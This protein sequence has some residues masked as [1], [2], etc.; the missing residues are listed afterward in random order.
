MIH[1]RMRGTAVKH[2]FSSLQTQSIW[3]RWFHGTGA[4]FTT[5]SRTRRPVSWAGTRMRRPAEG[6]RGGR[7]A[8][9][10]KVSLAAPL[11][12]RDAGTNHGQRRRL[13]RHSR[14]RS[15]SVRRTTEVPH[16]MQSETILIGGRRLGAPVRFPVVDPATLN[17]LVECSDATD[18]QASQAVDAAAAELRLWSSTPADRR[19]VLLNGLALLLEAEIESLSKLIVLE[20]GKPRP[21]AAR[22]VMSAAAALRWAGEEG[23]RVYGQ[24]IPSSSRDL[25]IWTYPQPLGVV[26]AMTGWQE[27][28]AGLARRAGAALAAGCTL[29]V[30]PAA[31]TPLS[32]VEFGV[33]ARDAGIPAG[34]VNVVTSSRTREVTH[35]WMNDPRIRKVCY[36][37]PA[38]LGR[39]LMRAASDQ[40]Q[41]LSLE[42][43]TN[44][45]AL[46]FDD[47]HPAEAA[48][49]VLSSRFRQSGQA[50]GSIQRVYLQEQVADAVEALLVRGARELQTGNGMNAGVDCGPLID[51]AAFT[52]VNQHLVDALQ[53][54]GEL[55]TGGRRLHLAAP[56]LGWFFEPTV[57]RMPG[58]RSLLLSDPL[59]GP[60]LAISRFREEHEAIALAN[61]SGYGSLAYLFTQDVT[62]VHRIPPRLRAAMTAVNVAG[63][64]DPQLP[65]SRNGW[66]GYGRE[67]GPGHLQEYLE[68]RSVVLRV[69]PEPA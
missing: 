53:N 51:E 49:A 36:S 45:A 66:F 27:P 62:R 46:I 18:E 39:E 64:S 14:G 41:R 19:S 32:A 33:L 11:C 47:A 17:L 31:Q 26:L 20:T 67:S 55:L 21:D 48:Q 58:V 24:T 30:K 43:G 69:N 12:V 29:I 60:V 16:D 59:P 65:L 50:P 40:V 15:L 7:G 54:G 10:D 22:E 34:V 2:Q 57:V 68:M 42:F 4:T 1:G 63:V 56:N 38:P 61:S 28:L 13:V 23:R 8:T 44:A 35:L 6:V 9:R 5:I 52:L 25:Q 37:G 3:L